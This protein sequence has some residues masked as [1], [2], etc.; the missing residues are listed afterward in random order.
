MYYDKKGNKIDGNKWIEL[1]QDDDYRRIARDDINSTIV[2]TVWLGIDHSMRRGGPH[3][4]FETAIF[5]DNPRLD[6]EMWCYVTEEEA[7]ESH[8]KIVDDII[9]NNKLGKVGKRL[10]P[11]DCKSVASASNV[12]IIPF[13]PNGVTNLGLWVS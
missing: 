6:H 1:L 7:M 3:F 13:P 2:S 8:K 11:A 10:N 12:R 9:S 4:I 5:P